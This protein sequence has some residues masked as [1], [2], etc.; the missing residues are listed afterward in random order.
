MIT[1][2]SVPFINVDAFGIFM[3]SFSLEAFIV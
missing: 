3:N 2:L 1:L